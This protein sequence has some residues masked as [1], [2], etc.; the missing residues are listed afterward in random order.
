[1]RRDDDLLFGE[2][3]L[4]RFPVIVVPGCGKTTLSSARL[5]R[6]LQVHEHEVHYLP[7]P[8]LALGD[9]M[10]SALYLRRRLDE[11]KV[12]LG[13]SRLNIICLG[14]GGLI[15]RWAIEHL[16]QVNY[17]NKAI[18]LGAPFH[19]A[20]KLALVGFAPAAYQ[21]IPS[22]IFM[23]RCKEQPVEEEMLRR[24]YSI[25][26]RFH[27]LSY[28]RKSSY[29]EG[30][31]NIRI[32]WFCPKPCLFHSKRVFSLILDILEGQYPLKTAMEQENK[33]AR[34]RL[35][36][37]N[38]AVKRNPQDAYSYLMRGSFF[39]ERG[40]WTRAIQDLNTV[41]RIR[42]DLSE[43]YYLRALAYRRKMRY[44]ENPIQNRS[45]RDLSRIISIRPGF[46]EAYYERGVCYALLNSWG[47]ALRDW[48]HALILNRDYHPAYL[49]RGLARMKM[50]ELM[51]ARDDFEEVL[52]LHPDNYDALRFLHEIRRRT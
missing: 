49:A 45:I 48:D 4:R 32:D 22:S 8:L 34:S 51:G 30:A 18:F 6:F 33:K 39:L 44:N 15:L 40:C 12:L 11:F 41:I 31:N 42:P 50:G 29:L 23:R 47:D 24:Y 21:M 5:R 52:R 2:G 10:K 43:A 38:G 20:Y 27:P 25:Y 17:L 19:G 36:E 46:A 16:H 7:L 14:E 37:L 1:M 26:T 28:P 9:M 35:D 3:D 13:A